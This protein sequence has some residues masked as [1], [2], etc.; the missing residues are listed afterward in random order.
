M[1]DLVEKSAILCSMEN[2][3]KRPG[4]YKVKLF[5]ETILEWFAANARKFPW[6]NPSIS[7]Y[8]K[9]MSEILLQ[10]TKAATVAKIYKG[11]M[12]KFPSWKKLAEASREELEE[13]LKP[14]GLFRQRAGR[15]FKLAQEMKK[16]NGRLPKTKEELESL[17]MFG[18][19]I[20][21]AVMLFVHD[22][23]APLLDVNMSRVLERF[24]GPRKMSDIRYDPYLQDL[25]SRVVNHHESREIN[26]GIL[27]FAALVCQARKPKCG[28]CPLSSKCVYS[29]QIN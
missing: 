14:L 18:Q 2:N 9:V 4:D 15:V 13:S 6:R 17:S 28:I 10:R 25:A 29:T 19:Y 1:L 24:F 26:W 22:S 23:P 8:Q 27:D 7:N 16:R 12:A 21:H 11:F 5:R 20:V 3:P